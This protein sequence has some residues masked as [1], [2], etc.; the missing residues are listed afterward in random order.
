MKRLIGVFL[1]LLVLAAIPTYFTM[2]SP[3]IDILSD[4]NL[5]QGIWVSEKTGKEGAFQFTMDRNGEEFTGVIAISGSPLTKGGDIKGTIEGDKIT[6][7]MGKN[8]RGKLTYTGTI[9]S[10]TMLGTWQIPIVKEHGSWQAFKKE[11]T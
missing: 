10:N 6:F 9:S 4:G 7:G 3:K 1:I 8:K 2:R 11:E 5:W